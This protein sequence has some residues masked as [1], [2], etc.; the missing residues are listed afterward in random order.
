MG[1]LLNFA[2]GAIFK[3]NDGRQHNAVAATGGNERIENAQEKPTG[4]TFGPWADH[5]PN[6]KCNVCR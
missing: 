1:R 3:D 6:C 2:K 4:A 5:G